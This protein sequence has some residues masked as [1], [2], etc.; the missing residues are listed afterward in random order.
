MTTLEVE[1]N[2]R[3]ILIATLQ[4]IQEDGDA[5]TIAG[6]IVPKDKSTGKVFFNFSFT[7]DEN[8]MCELLPNKG[9]LSHK[10]LTDKDEDIIDEITDNLKDT[11]FDDKQE[12]LN[13]MRGE[14]EDEDEDEAERAETPP[15]TINRR[16]STDAKSSEKTKSTKSRAKANISEVGKLGH[17]CTGLD[18]QI[19]ALKRKKRKAMENTSSFDD[20]TQMYVKALKDYGKTRE[21]KSLSGD[22]NNMLSTVD[23]IANLREE[24]SGK[25]HVMNKISPKSKKMEGY[26][27]P[28]LKVFADLLRATAKHIETKIMDV[29]AIEEELK[30][31]IKE[32]F[33][34]S[35][36]KTDLRL[37]NQ[38]KDEDFTIADL[39]GVKLY[40][41]VSIFTAM[42]CI[43]VKMFELEK[44]TQKNS[45]N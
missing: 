28:I 30:E 13:S 36:R 6:H 38:L 26:D 33:E 24:W 15:K 34:K 40:E 12:E 14:D 27:Q 2:C 7:D 37:Q 1:T 17:E 20:D 43:Y 18:L 3:G 32:L 41:W 4:P 16:K 5:L 44:N 45:T 39:K 11:I 22:I 35:R 42:L 25:T 29:E 23:D 8:Y 21:G 9:L 31:K 10:K 19:T